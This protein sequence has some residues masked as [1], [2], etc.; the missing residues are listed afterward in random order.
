MI[1]GRI[2]MKSW[3]RIEFIWAVGSTN[4]TM[5]NSMVIRLWL[6]SDHDKV[7]IFIGVSCFTMFTTIIHVN[8]IHVWVTMHMHFK[9]KMLKYAFKWQCSLKL[10]HFLIN[11]NFAIKNNIGTALHHIH[12]DHSL[13]TYQKRDSRLHTCT[14]PFQKEMSLYFLE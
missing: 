1:I 12:H 2:Q 14:F 6:S 10:T 3:K 8:Y 13:Q 9:W 7:L 5:N 4:F 11:N